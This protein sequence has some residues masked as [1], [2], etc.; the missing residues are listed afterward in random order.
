LLQKGCFSKAAI[1]Q[2][3]SLLEDLHFHQGIFFSCSPG[4][5]GGFVMDTVVTDLFCSYSAKGWHS[6][7]HLNQELHKLQQIS[8]IK[9]TMV[10]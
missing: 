1:G 2:I 6:Q 3:V 8:P 10:G 4:F 7:L 5:W 9:F